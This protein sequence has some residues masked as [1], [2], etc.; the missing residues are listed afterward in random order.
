M[1]YH[2][3]DE[4]ILEDAEQQAQ[5]SGLEIYIIYRK[6]KNSCFHRYKSL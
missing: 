4:Q 1:D 2:A 3:L 5:M 6:L